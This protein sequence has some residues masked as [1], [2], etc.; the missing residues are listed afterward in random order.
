[1]EQENI[2]HSRAPLMNHLVEFRNR[3]IKACWALLA[4][5]AVSYYFSENIYEFLLIPLENAYQDHEAHKLI[6]TGLT[7]AFLT[8]IHL[9]LFAGLFLAFPVIAYQLYMFLAPGMYKKERKVLLP[10]LVISPL[11]FFAGG[12]IAYYYIFPLAWKFFISF[13][14]QDIMLQARVSEYLSLVMRLI[15][16]FGFASQLP[17]ILTL[18]TRIGLVKAENLVRGRKYAILIIVIVSAFI[19]PPDVFSQIGLSIPLYLLYEISIILCKRI[20]KKRT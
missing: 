10:Y 6:Y 4:G 1:M 17:V 13:E 11:L 3:L 18:L 2:E 7:E 5:F 12:A 19:T 8:Y 16:A 14:T 20:E 15:I 9:S